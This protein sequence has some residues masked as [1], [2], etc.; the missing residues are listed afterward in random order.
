[1]KNKLFLTVVLIGLATFSAQARV[2]FGVSFGIPLP[3]PVVVTTP[4]VPVVAGPVAVAAPVVVAGPV[5]SAPGYVWAPGYWS[6][7]G[8]NRVWVAGCWHGRPGCAVYGHS[9]GRR[10]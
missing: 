5:V 1:M 9:Y 7:C 3:A 8:Y 2:Y 10:W 4:Y 6:V